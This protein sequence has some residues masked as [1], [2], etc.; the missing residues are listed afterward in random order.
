MPQVPN[1]YYPADS[2]WTEIINT[3]TIDTYIKSQIINTRN[4]D[5]TIYK[6]PLTDIKAATP[7]T[8]LSVWFKNEVSFTRGD[9]LETATYK[10]YID[11]QKQHEDKETA[12]ILTNKLSEDIKYTLLLNGNL[13]GKCQSVIIQEF[14]P[15]EDP[16]KEGKLWTFLGCMMIEIQTGYLYL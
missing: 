9:N 12:V 15:I 10:F 11:I 4:K 6:L 2:I 13:S 7:E 3:L 16:R 5:V 1:G 8:A 14:E